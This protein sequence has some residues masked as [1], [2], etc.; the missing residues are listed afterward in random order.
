MSDTEKITINLSVVDLGRIDLLSEEGFYSN[1]TDFIRT[2]IR[3]QID[4][5]EFDVK[6]T[7][8]RKSMVMGVIGYGQKQLEKLL[9]SG[10]QVAIRAVGLVIIESDVS[11]ELAMKTIESIK[12]YGVLRADNT[13][14]KTLADKIL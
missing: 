9:A 2:A 8:T 1:R 13:V 4:K 3:N 14:K 6:Q 5:H 7:M 11:P 12:V 10:E